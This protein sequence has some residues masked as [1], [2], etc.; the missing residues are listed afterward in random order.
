MHWCMLNLLGL[1]ICRR[2]NGPKSLTSVDIDRIVQQVV[3]GLHSV[4][5]DRGGLPIGHGSWYKAKVM[6][7]Y[8][9]G[10]WW[11]DTLSVSYP[12]SLPKSDVIKSQISCPPVLWQSSS[13]WDLS[14]P[15]QPNHYTSSK[16]AIANKN[17]T[18]LCKHNFLVTCY[19]WI[20]EPSCCM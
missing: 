19:L 13:C 10:R 16:L 15:S 12:C 11:D 14:C 7:N 9:W 2:C 1:S 5:W 18:H 20:P 3:I 4:K 6:L 8:K 17:E